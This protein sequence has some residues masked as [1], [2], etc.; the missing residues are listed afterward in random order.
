MKVA[1]QGRRSFTWSHVYEIAMAPTIAVAIVTEWLGFSKKVFAVTPKG[2][3]TDKL[4]FR[5]AIASPHIVLL[6]LS[7][8]ALLNA[9]VLSP[10]EFNFGSVVIISFWTVYNL[11]GL[12]MAILVCLER[13]RKRSTERTEV[14]LPVEVRLWKGA[15]VEGRVLDLSFNGVRFALPW[16][17]AFGPTEAARQ[18]KQIG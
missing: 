18:L 14:D 17:N 15:P 5:V 10:G 13:P 1:S 11:V 9:F 7:L 12:V 3:S 6:G 8:Y 16:S 2:V 4:N